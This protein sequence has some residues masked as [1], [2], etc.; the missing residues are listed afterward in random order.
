MVKSNE[1]FNKEDIFYLIF[2]YLLKNDLS[3]TAKK[4]LKETNIDP[5]L[6]VI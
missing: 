5:E 3:K 1:L 2:R 4:L 6:P